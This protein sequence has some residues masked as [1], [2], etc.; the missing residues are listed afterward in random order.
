MKLLLDKCV[1]G[2][3]CQ[4]LEAAGYDVAWVGDWDEDPGDEA[5]L[6]FANDQGRI[7][8]TLDHD[9]GDLAVQF[10]RLHCGIIRVRNYR[11]T[12]QAHGIFEA[13]EQY[14]EDLQKG[15]VVVVQ[16]GRIRLRRP[17][18]SSIPH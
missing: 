8:I 3:V 14:G 9:F 1:S 11:I 2:L 15:A 4:H 18:E 6:Q 17:T 10:G 7:I 13:L 5:I 12:N 16:P